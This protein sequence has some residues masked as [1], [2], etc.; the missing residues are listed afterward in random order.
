MLTLEG[1]TCSNGVFES[2]KSIHALTCG[3]LVFTLCRDELLVIPMKKC[4]SFCGLCMMPVEQSRANP[5]SHS[6]SFILV[7]TSPAAWLYKVPQTTLSSNLALLLG[8]MQEQYRRSVWAKSKGAV[9]AQR[10]TLERP[11]YS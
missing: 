5:Q 7:I 11:I 8:Y 3:C 1:S 10:N 9:V 2:R 6:H 4:M